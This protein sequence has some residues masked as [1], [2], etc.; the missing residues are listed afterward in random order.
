MLKQE[1]IEYGRRFAVYLEIENTKRQSIKISTLP[2]I[3]A[4]LGDVSQKLIK[5]KGILGNGPQPKEKIVTVPPHSMYALR[6]DN[7][8]AGVMSHEKS[9]ITL[10]LG[11]SIWELTTGT[12]SLQLTVTFTKPRLYK[13]NLWTGSIN[14]ENREIIIP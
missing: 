5:S 12:Y 11:N 13:D 10:A 3:I 9:G 1:S 4:S 6:I 8:F 2:N 14:F 7:Q